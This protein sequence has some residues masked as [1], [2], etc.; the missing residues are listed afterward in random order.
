MSPRP[1]PAAFGSSEG[2]TGGGP[3]ESGAVLG[4][5][6]LLRARTAAMQQW[7]T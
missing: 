6:V 7:G 3:R 1:V 4:E 2:A 5:G